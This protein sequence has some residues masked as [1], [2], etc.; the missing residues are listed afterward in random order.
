[1]WAELPE[2]KHNETPTN[3]RVYE[4]ELPTFTSDVRMEKIPEI[5]ASSAD[6]VKGRSRGKWW[7]R[8]G[9]GGVLD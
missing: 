4:T 9:G 1:M 2:N 3:E 5:F 7:W 8:A 6:T